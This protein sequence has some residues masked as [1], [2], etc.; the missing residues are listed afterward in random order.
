MGGQIPGRDMAPTFQVDPQFEGR[1]GGG[2]ARTTKRL[3]LPSRR[4]E[5]RGCG[6]KS[7][8]HPILAYFMYY[9]RVRTSLRSV[10]LK[11]S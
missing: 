3:R 9:I 8:S 4:G 6:Y 2:L 7:Y 5:P 11:F 10:T 1:D